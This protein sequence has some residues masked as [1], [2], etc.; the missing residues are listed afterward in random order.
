ME[1]VHSC[2]NNSDSLQ[3]T[4]NSKQ[5]GI[6]LVD[7]ENLVREGIA[8]IISSFSGYKVVAHAK[9]VSQAISKIEETK[10]QILLSEIA[11]NGASGLELLLELQRRKLSHLK[12]IILSQVNSTDMVKQALLAGAAGY[13]FKS[14]EVNDLKDALDTSLTNKRYLPS[15][16]V[17]LLNIRSPSFE[18]SGKMQ[19]NDPLHELSTRER[20][21]FHLLARGLQNTV[22]AQK[23]F[24]SP[25]TVETHRARIVRKLKIVS[26]GELI[27]FA[28]KHGLAVV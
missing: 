10:P 3:S 6:L 11:L 8:R 27:R 18:L 5:V 23:L 17:G 13:I 19:I 22:I 26:N 2:F 14:C 24:I 15:Q 20:E 25:R 4:N 28:I 1:Q 9:D 21:I 12:A 7:S 16:L